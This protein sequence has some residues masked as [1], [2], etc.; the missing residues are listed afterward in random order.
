[1]IASSGNIVL[2]TTKPK[3]WVS[4]SRQTRGRKGRVHVAVRGTPLEHQCPRHAY[5]CHVVSLFRGENLRKATR[6]MSKTNLCR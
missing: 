1:M 2:T 6:D 5:P 3:P 4:I